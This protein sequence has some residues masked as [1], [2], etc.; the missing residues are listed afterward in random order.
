MRSRSSRRDE[1]WGRQTEGEGGALLWGPA[2]GG[3]GLP[4][5]GPRRGG[6]G[7]GGMASRGDLR[8]LRVGVLGAGAS[9]RAAAGLAVARG[10]EAAVVLDAAPGPPRGWQGGDPRRGAAAVWGVDMGRSELPRMAAG[11]D[12]LVLSP[13]V[14][15]G[16]ALVQGAL[17]DPR[18][19]VLSEL[20]FAAEALPAGLPLL[21]VSGTNGKSTVCTFA[22]QFLQ[23]CF[24]REGRGRHAWAGGNLGVPLSQAALACL[25]GG[26]GD[27]R[28][29]AP[30]RSG[31]RGLI[32]PAAAL[33]WRVRARG[34]G[35]P[36]P[37]R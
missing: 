31:R 2:P 15:P 8:G 24:D 30:R 16:Q 25:G 5:R 14:D 27:G 10:A 11:L 7:A 19:E 26:G 13:G 22:A 20:E 23:A 35:R 1:H 28:G 34:R 36:E 33:W 37:H 12:R 6:P 9:G 29:T 18:L 32:V 17:A 3:G 4:G 21:A